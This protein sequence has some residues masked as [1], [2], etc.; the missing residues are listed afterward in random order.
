M[1]MKLNLKLT[2]ATALLF[3]S[4]AGFAQNDKADAILGKFHS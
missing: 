3:A 2:A 4:I 1:Y